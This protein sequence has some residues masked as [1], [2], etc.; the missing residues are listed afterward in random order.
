MAEDKQRSFFTI[1]KEHASMNA[2]DGTNARRFRTV[3]RETASHLTDS[4]HPVLFFNASTR[5][6]R[7]SL[8]AAYAWITANSLRYSG[9]P[10]HF[11]SCGVGLQPCACFPWDAAEMLCVFPAWN[12][13]K[14]YMTICRIRI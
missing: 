3:N 1:L 6:N 5:L 10:I 2:T 13:P 4:E 8:N 9:V 14:I 7:T 11:L 12:F